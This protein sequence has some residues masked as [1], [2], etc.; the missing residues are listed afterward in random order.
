[1]E[2]IR[3]KYIQQ[4]Q[5]EHLISPPTPLLCKIVPKSLKNRKAAIPGL[6]CEGSWY[7]ICFVSWFN[8]REAGKLLSLNNGKWVQFG[9]WCLQTLNT[10]S[11]KRT[12]C[13]HP[14]RFAVRD[15]VYCCI[16]FL[17]R[18]TIIF[19]RGKQGGGE[20]GDI[21]AREGTN[22]TTPWKYSHIKLLLR[23]Y[24]LATE[25]VWWD[26]TITLLSW[27]I[28]EVGAI[29]PDI[30]DGPPDFNLRWKGHEVLVCCDNEVAVL[31]TLRNTM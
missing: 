10:V 15:T 19:Y 16:I 3:E 4:T 6:Y 26:R 9:N 28:T 7:F 14:C 11:C 30:F 20:G 27:A 13:A 29:I 18:R 5:F 23:T 22:F 17:V 8:G 12:C 25:W 31:T 24:V 2:H 21:G 1:M